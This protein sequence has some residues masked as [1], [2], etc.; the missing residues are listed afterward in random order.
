MPL[1]LQTLCVLQ[2]LSTFCLA[3]TSTLPHLGAV[4]SESDVCSE[5]GANIL[6][7]RGNAADA[8]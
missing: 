6:Q 4:A 1:P 3:V 7:I 8:V 2:L 5:I